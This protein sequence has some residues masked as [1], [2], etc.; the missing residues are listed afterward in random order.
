MS[1]TLEQILA[2]TEFMSRP[3]LK[4][5]PRPNERLSQQSAGHPQRRGHR[6]EVS[7]QAPLKQG[8]KSHLPR[9]QSKS[10]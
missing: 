2:F 7:A 1:I 5:A 4:G 9:R 6:R 8:P 10:P 3:A